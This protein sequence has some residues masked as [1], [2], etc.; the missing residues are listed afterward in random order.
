MMVVVVDGGGR[1]WCWFSMVVIVDGGGWVGD[2]RLR[3]S[4]M[5]VVWVVVLV[6][7]GGR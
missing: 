5:V 2:G 7:D 4:M 6:D 1:C 3:W